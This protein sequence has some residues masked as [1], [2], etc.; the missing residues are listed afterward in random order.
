MH[1][2][3]STLRPTDLRI[4]TRPALDLPKN[5]IEGSNPF[6][7][8]QVKQFLYRLG[9]ALRVAGGWISQISR[10]SAH[11]GGKVVSLTYRPPLPPQEIILVLMSVG[12]W[13]NTRAIVRPED[14]CQWKI[15]VTPSGIE[16]ASFRLVAQ[17]LNQLCHRLHP[18]TCCGDRKSPMSWTFA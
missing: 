17:C 11:E 18:H 10:Q 13:V 16:L 14:L 2:T 1:E 4:K 9:Q 8:T 15:P 12:G 3:L 7:S 6:L 5:R